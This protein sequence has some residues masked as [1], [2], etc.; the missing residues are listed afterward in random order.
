MIQSLLHYYQYTFLGTFWQ[1]GGVMVH[2]NFRLSGTV[3][4]YA[5]AAA[6]SFFIV[7]CAGFAFFKKIRSQKKIQERTGFCCVVVFLVCSTL[8]MLFMPVAL[9]G[10]SFLFQRFSVF[11]FLG[12]ILAASIVAPAGLPGRMKICVCMVLAL[13]SIVWFQCFRAFDSENIGFNEKFF[14]ECSRDDVLV[15]LTYDYRFRNVS[16]YNNFPDYYTAWTGGVSAT[17]MV[18][19]R[20]FVISRKVGTDLLPE[21]LVWPGEGDSNRYDGRYSS[22]DYILVRGALPV[23]A[24]DKLQNFRLAKRAGAWRLYANQLKSI[25]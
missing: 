25:F 3:P 4:G 14:E 1:R 20:S 8:C 24:S 21:Y 17:R 23:E 18:D 9:P 16:V 6:F 10:Y 15:G 2:D 22:V 5:A 11:V 13:H 7:F 19:D 12:I